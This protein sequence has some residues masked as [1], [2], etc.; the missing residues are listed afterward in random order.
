MGVPFLVKCGVG[1]LRRVIYCDLY[2]L[3][4]YERDVII[5]SHILSSVANGFDVGSASFE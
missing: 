1:V 5:I 2:R 4:L 3:I